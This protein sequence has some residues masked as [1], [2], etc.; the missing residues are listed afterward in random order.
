[1]TSSYNI[2]AKYKSYLGRIFILRKHKLIPAS[3]EKKFG[4]RILYEAAEIFGEVVYILDETNS[5]VQ[6]T[7]PSGKMLWIPKYYLYKE[8][9]SQNLNDSLS[10]NIIN[11][12][13]SDLLASNM[14]DE[15]KI[16]ITQILK[17]IADSL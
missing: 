4:K 9:E 11:E 16:S 6:V 17:S 10:K 14:S 3:T 15:N 1:M 7:T 13:S 2:P 8:V 5:K 12:L